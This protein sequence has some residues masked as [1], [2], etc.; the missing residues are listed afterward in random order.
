MRI[1]FLLVFLLP[2]VVFSQNKKD[3]KG[4]RTGHWIYFGKDRPSSGYKP[5]VKIE[6]GNYVNGYKEGIW[7]KY[8]PDGKT[9]KLNGNYVNNRP[10]GAYSR[11]YENGKLKEQGNFSYNSFKGKYIRNH[12][13]GQPAYK[14]SYN[15]TGKESGLV[16]Y[17]YPNGQIELEYSMKDGKPTGTLQRYFSDGSLKEKTT[18]SSDG[19]LQNVQKYETKK[20]IVQPTTTVK[21]PVSPP[22]VEKPRTKGLKFNPEGHNRLYNENDAI[23][24]DG[25]FKGGQLWD[26][27]VF[28]YDIDGI[29]KKVRIFK[30][31]KYHSDGQL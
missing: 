26:G 1:S 11:F 30:K 28:E 27:K 12:S 16:Q 3:S 29:S 20:I 13:N 7:V 19:K 24:I 22:F 18:F 6:E 15:S 31:G 9:A 25:L 2:C 23:W 21:K 5:Q 8:Y 4:K 14:A 10:Y 17:F